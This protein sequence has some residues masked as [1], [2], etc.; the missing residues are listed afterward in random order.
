M[1][2]STAHIAKAAGMRSLVINFRQAQV[3]RELGF[4]VMAVVRRD[5]DA[6]VRLPK[7]GVAWADSQRGAGC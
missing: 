6:D 1:H 2:K 3:R 5:E 7:P 4:S